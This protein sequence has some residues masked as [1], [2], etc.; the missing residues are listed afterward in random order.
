MDI[1]NIRICP[2]YIRSKSNI[3]ADNL[4]RELDRND[5]QLNPR[6]IFSYLQ[7]TWGPYTIFRFASMET[8]QLLRFN[9]KWRNLQCEDVECL[10]CTPS[11]RRLATR[12]EL[13]QPA[14]GSVTYTQRKAM[15]IG[16]GRAGHGT[17]FARLIESPT[18][19][20]V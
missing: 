18:Q 13:I 10:H 9:A 16:S 1:N 5:G 17:T 2:R 11:I 19:H 12:S 7:F 8:T 15:T 6:R 20:G 14:V 4:S 3:W